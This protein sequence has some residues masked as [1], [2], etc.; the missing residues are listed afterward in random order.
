MRS[1]TQLHFKTISKMMHR[2]ELQK[3]NISIKSKCVHS[4]ISLNA[5]LLKVTVFLDFPGSPVVKN[6]P[7]DAG[8]LGSIPGWGTQILHTMGQLRPHAITK[9]ACTLQGRP[10]V[11]KTFKKLK[12]NSI[13]FLYRC[14]VQD[15][16]QFGDPFS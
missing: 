6:I 14:R 12:H 4:E 9:E 5:S 13:S 2:V 8:D 16:K 1:E 11:A 15:L 10:N 3:A 7:C